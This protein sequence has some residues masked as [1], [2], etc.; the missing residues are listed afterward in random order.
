MTAGG[1]LPVGG[2]A[3]AIELATESLEGARLHEL[4]AEARAFGRLA[5]VSLAGRPAYLLTRHSDIKTF[6]AAHEEYPGGPMYAFQIE[7][8]VGR[9]FISMDG[10]EHDVYRQLAMPA[11]RSRAVSRFVDSELVPLAHEIV[12][13]FAARGEADLV[14]EFTGVLPFLAI[15]RKLGVTATDAQRELARTMLS[16]PWSPDEAVA[17]GMEVTRF[18]EPVLD[19]RRRH[20]GDDV[21]SHLLSAEFKG[22]RLTEAEVVSHIRLLYAVGATT[23]SDAMSSLFWT[24]LTQPGL[25]ERARREPAV[26]GCI[27]EELLRW[28]P[29]VAILPRMAARG[30]VVG[31]VTVP[32]GTLILAALSAANRAPEVFADADCFDPDR[33]TSE[34]L[35]FGYGS[36]HC[37]GAHLGYQQLRAGLD[38]ILERLPRLRLVEASKPSGAILRAV[39]RLR[40][41]WG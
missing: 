32:D 5:P 37:P 19:E 24:L 14:A 28:E 35:T 7:P 1:H 21:L 8:V 18:I 9:T 3:A 4:L 33:D 38:V 2:P 10:T 11:F 13:G 15:S 26:R 6:L 34:A 41:A 29:P 17:A 16:Y 23:T 12:D 40:V 31:G 30:G 25:L 20:P 22:T 39:P 36:K 27:V